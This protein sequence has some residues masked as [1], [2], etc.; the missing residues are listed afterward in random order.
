[1]KAFG[2]SLN[3]QSI[4]F[5]YLACISIRFL[6]LREYKSIF[7]PS[8]STRAT[9]VFLQFG[10]TFIALPSLSKMKHWQ[11]SHKVILLMVAWLIWTCLATFLGEYP[12]G[13]IIRWFEILTS[14]IFSYC[15]YLLVQNTPRYKNLIIYSLITTLIFIITTY[16]AVWFSLDNPV[17]FEWVPFSPFV[18]NI[19]HTGYIAAA[20]LPLGYWLRHDGSTYDDNLVTT[21][22]R[23]SGKQC[24]FYSIHSPP[25]PVLLSSL[26]K[27]QTIK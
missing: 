25:D 26:C 21:A 22:A 20:L 18:N 3:K 8:I 13:G 12:W 2:V 14:I 9:P 10:F 11:G 5:L 7:K 6:L 23:Y 24:Q 15:V 17:T 19:R 27:K 4:P 1:M 16:V